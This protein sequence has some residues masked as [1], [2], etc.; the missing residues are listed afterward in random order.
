MAT[1]KHR[2]IDLLRRNKRIERK[3]EELGYQL[4]ARQKSAA[5]NLDA[6]LDDDVGDNLLWLVFTACHPMLTTEARVALTRNAR[7]RELL[8]GRARACLPSQPSNIEGE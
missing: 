5:P 6:A 2:A 8:L 7:E 3:H 4:A 1:A